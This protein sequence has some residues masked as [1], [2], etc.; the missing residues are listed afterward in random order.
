MGEAGFIDVTVHE[1]FNESGMATARRPPFGAE[2]VA[3]SIRQGTMGTA[4]HAR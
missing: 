4:A 2:S 3:S 1:L